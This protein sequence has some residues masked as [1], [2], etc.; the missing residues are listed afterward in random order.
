MAC[1]APTRRYCVAPYLGQSAFTEEKLIARSPRIVGHRG[2]CGHAPENT[3]ASI[4]RAAELGAD[5][6]EFDCMLTG[7]GVPV[8]FHDD[9][10][11]RTTGA[12]GVVS[13][14]AYAAMAALDAGA[15]FSPDFAG[16]RVPSL[17]AALRLID[18]RR[19][20]LGA[21]PE[22]KPCKGFD[23]ETGAAVARTVTR[24]WPA[25]L[26]P[27]LL[28]SFSLPALEAA[29]EVAPRIAR[30]LLCRPIPP[31]WRDI[32]AGIGAVG[33]HCQDRHLTPRQAEAVKAAGLALWV[34]TVNDGQRALELF[35]WGVDA[36]ITDF[37]DRIAAALGRRES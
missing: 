21:A 33:I 32:V 1:G 28:A 29:R 19:L 12:G 30:R 8:L 11:K 31:D 14:T 17:E 15:W 7:D 16:E 20:G 4:V 22:I 35:G 6:V 10:L 2:A 9:K 27:P 34:F 24:H 3:L 37:P 25:H 5:W 18:E 36:V 23:A 26:P 13:E